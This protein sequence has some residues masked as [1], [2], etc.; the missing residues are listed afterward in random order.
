M[1]NAVKKACRV[2][3]AAYDE[4]LLDLIEAAKADL[5]LAGVEEEKVR[6]DTDPLIRRAVTTFCRMNFGAPE[7]YDKLKASYDEQKAQL[8]G[9]GYYAKWGN[10]DGES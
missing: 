5:A 2:T 9:A 6:N 7:N 4:E 10:D 8:Q 3:A 1:L